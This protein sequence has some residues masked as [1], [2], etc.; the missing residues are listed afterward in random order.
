M[1]GILTGL[2][3][4]ATMFRVSVLEPRVT[5][6]RDS[7]TVFRSDIDGCKLALVVSARLAAGELR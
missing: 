2:W 7:L 1:T 4:I 3:V 5:V 6:I